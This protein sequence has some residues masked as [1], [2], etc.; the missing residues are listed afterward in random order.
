MNELESNVKSLIIEKYGSMKKFCE[1]IDMPWTTLDSILKRGIANS[2]ITNVLKITRELGIDAEKLVE[3]QISYVDN[4]PITLA[5]HF[6]G[7][8]YTESEMDEILQFAEFV[9]NKRK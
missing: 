8:E 9:K 7:N 6:D 2:N 4:K 5:A 3:G 1:T